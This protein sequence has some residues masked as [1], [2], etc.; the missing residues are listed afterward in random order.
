MLGTFLFEPQFRR[1]FSFT[2]GPL[3]FSEITKKSS[4][5]P[6]PACFSAFP[7]AAARGRLGG[8]LLFALA[9]HVSRPTFSTALA[10]ALELSSP[11][12]APQRPPPA[13]TSS[14]PWQARIESQ[15]PLLSCASEQED[16][17]DLFPS[18]SCCFLDPRPRNTSAIH[19]NAG[20]PQAH[21]RPT[22]PR[23]LRPRQPHH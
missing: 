2:V 10:L 12:H 14:S 6:P 5:L 20:E 8:H 13:A 16:L 17:L 11:C 19:P 9:T 18:L 7:V 1:Y 15:L 4:R 21:C 22:P 3:E 23:P